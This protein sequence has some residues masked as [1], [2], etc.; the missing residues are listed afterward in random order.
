M[1]FKK[2]G[3]GAMVFGFILIFV[4][5]YPAFIVKHPAGITLFIVGWIMFT[6]GAVQR[7]KQK[8]N[9]EKLEQ[10]MYNWAADREKAR[11]QQSAAPA[12][13]F[14]Q[15]APTPTDY[16]NAQSSPGKYSFRVAGLTYR[17]NAVQAVIKRNPFY[18]MDTGTL[19]YSDFAMN[20]KIYEYSSEL[21]EPQF[22]PDPSNPHDPNA[23][24][25]YISEWFVGYVPKDETAQV[26]AILAAKYKSRAWLSGGKWKCVH[27]DGRV[28]SGE[29]ALNINVDLYT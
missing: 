9:Q 20:R 19:Q 21:P 18:G 28:T 4:M 6:V 17:M 13:S 22:S 14:L 12:A 16:R 27:E 29:D 26:S 25:V 11:L 7:G 1:K 23:I 10:E 3:V 24:G 8:K 5:I 15:P 2:K